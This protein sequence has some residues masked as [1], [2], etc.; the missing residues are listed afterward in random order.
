MLLLLNGLFALL[1]LSLLLMNFKSE[2][3]NKIVKV[4]KNHIH[5]LVFN[6]LFF[7]KA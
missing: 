2:Y 4:C 5:Y 6:K 1:L 7:T 3:A